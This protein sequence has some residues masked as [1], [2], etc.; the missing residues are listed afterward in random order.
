LLICFF[1]KQFL[2]AKVGLIIKFRNNIAIKF[3]K[4]EEAPF[5][6]VGCFRFDAVSVRIASG[7]ADQLHAV[8]RMRGFKC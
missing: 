5:A 3:C 1:R 7:N 8:D 6:G 2:Y 4:K